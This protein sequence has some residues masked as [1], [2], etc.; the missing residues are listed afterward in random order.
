M[1][2]YIDTVDLEVIVSLAK[3]RGFIFQG[4]EIYGGLSSIWDYGPLGAELK[5]NVK[6]EWWR[7]CV[8]ARDDVVGLDSA[9]LMH[10]KVWVA[11]GHTDNFTDPLSECKDCHH[12]FRADHIEGKS[13]PDC[14]GALTEPRMFNLMLKTF[15]GPTEESSNQVYMR[16]ETAQGI[17]VNFINVLNS[18][19]RKLPFG[20]AQIG[21]S[22]R[23][24]ITPGNFIF[25]TREFEQMEIEFFVK[26][27]S[28]EEWHKRWLKDRFDW[29]V[30]LGIR[31][32]KLRIRKHGQDEL[33]HY[34]KATS[35]IEYKFPWGWGEL[36]GVANRTDFDLRQHSE[37]SGQDL[38]FYDDIDKE[39]YIP[40]VIEPSGGVDRSVLAFLI[41][42]YDEVPDPGQRQNRTLLK[43]HPQLAPIKIAILPLS[44]NEKLVPKAREIYA[45][46]KKSGRWSV[47]YDDAQSIGR[48]YRRQDEIGTP[49]CVTIDFETIEK[50]GAVTIRDRDTMEQSRIEIG[51][52]LTALSAKLEVL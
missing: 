12:R 50:D 33:S 46:V 20:I 19:R 2:R 10:P 14:G 23:N 6:E 29:Y 51:N 28:D 31:K 18:S 13:C 27:G 47:Q 35:D 36:E 24:E 16:P 42:A 30:N 9:I 5:R 4:S 17:F 1:S 32:D 44:R 26:P 25:R 52:L 15:L 7:S 49:I 34:S 8:Y 37:F 21:K 3:R 40:Y 45:M 39:R 43:L 22:F 48:R 11:S 41:D 38:S